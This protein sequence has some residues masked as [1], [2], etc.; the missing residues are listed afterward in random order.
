[1]Q[2]AGA[3]NVLRQELAAHFGRS[4]DSLES[5]RAEQQDL[6]LRRLQLIG[7]GGALHYTLSRKKPPS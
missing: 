6:Q 1:M 4:K 7:Q 5:G 3:A 2:D